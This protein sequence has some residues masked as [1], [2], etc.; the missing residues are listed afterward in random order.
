MYKPTLHTFEILLSNQ[1][2][3][4]TFCNLVLTSNSLTSLIF[5]RKLIL[6]W[7]FERSSGW[8]W[9]PGLN[10]TPDGGGRSSGSPS[11]LSSTMSTYP[12]TT[13]STLWCSRPSG[14]WT[15]SLRSLA[16][17]LCLWWSLSRYKIQAR[18]HLY[19][20]LSVHGGPD[21]LLDR[22]SLLLAVQKYLLLVE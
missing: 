2:L 14:S 18:V 3:S 13:Y 21:S 6:T 22:T 11:S 1:N 4:T 9:Y 16:Q 15:S 12:V 8:V 7:T 10:L 5:Q 19:P 17:Y 20:F